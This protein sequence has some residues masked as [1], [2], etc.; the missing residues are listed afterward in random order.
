MKKCFLSILLFCTVFRAIIYGQ[1]V[2]HWE[3]VVYNDDTW[4]YF[5]G[6]SE[7]SSGWRSLSFDDSSWPQGTGGFGYGD[8]DDNTTIPAC[9]S[10]YLRIK[11][12]IVDTDAIAS[13]LLNIDYDDAFVAYL[14]DVEIARVGISG[15]HPAY[16]QT[17]NDHEA[18][19]YRGGHPESFL[20]DKSK[21]NICLL[22]GDNVLAVQVHNSSVSSSDLTSNVFLSLG[23]TNTTYNYRLPP[24]WFIAPGEFS[25]SNLP[26][27]VIS[28]LPGETIM[29]EPKIT[30]DM[31]IIYNGGALLNYITDPGNIYSG[32]IGIEIRGRYSAALPQKPYGFETRD[33]EGNN[34]NV[35]VLGLPKEN[36]WI[37][38]ANYN[39]KTFLRNFL[40]FEIFRQMGHYAPGS[41]YCEVVVNNEYQGIYLLTEKI[42][43]DKNRVNISELNHFENPGDDNTGGYIFKNDY[44]T[45]ND[46]WL[47]NYSPVNKPGADVHFVYHDPDAG[48]IT[49]RQKDYIRD[50]VDTFESILY[51]PDFK[52]K[53]TGYRA[54]L[55]VNSFVDYFILGEITRNV[56][57]YKKSRFY[58]KD[59]ESIDGHIHS[60][61]PWDFDWAWKNITE[62]CVHF[63]QT[64]G[65]GWAY[66]INECDAWPV[67]P[68]WEIRL[69]QDRNF[70][71]EI[72]DR[73]Y[74]LRKNILSQAHLNHIIDSV[75][76]LLDAAQIRHYQ[77]WKILG[78]NVGTP[79][80]GEQPA[81][82]SGEIQKFKAWIGTR[83][84]WLDANMVGRS[85]VSPGN[86]KPVC[87]IFPNPA[88]ENLYFESDTLISK[89]ELYNYSG[90]RVAEKTGYRDYSVKI[91]LEHL[92]PGFYVAKIY[93]RYGGILTRKFVKEQ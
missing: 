55:D 93:F 91:N 26:I 18:I 52:D 70:V 86:Y 50:Y 89:I 79:E 7:P 24:S 29:D 87:R 64:D 66:R 39:D 48:E 13:A 77:K 62:N 36:D 61:P 53:Q 27:V 20:I 11:F 22:Q 76:A 10:V 90:I 78:I 72:H 21:L 58:Y 6:T 17:G 80:S 25:S 8:N 5:V 54:Y 3:T 60:G 51:S 42:K 30:A 28:T 75:A 40:A 68:S 2:N 9:T 74:L 41:R 31:K 81:T 63:N 1:S 15:I 45:S 69:M 16:N 65:S 82:Y 23:I 19:M 49:Q 59:K 88:G 38:A 46:S 34:L 73:Y 47:S 4:R 57:A 83:L 67:P 35:P 84:G 44:Y 92:G 56:D 33:N 71:N 43:I 14:N 12:N 37:L 85:Y 32:K